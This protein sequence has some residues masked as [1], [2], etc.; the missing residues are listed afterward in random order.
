MIKILTLAMAIYFLFSLAA[1]VSRAAPK[2]GDTPPQAETG[3]D[4]ISRGRITEM[5]QTEPFLC[6]MVES[7]PVPE[8]GEESP[9]TP[10]ESLQENS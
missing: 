4:G 6:G 10:V 7:V 5:Q 8:T 9:C 2:A 1:C 3:S